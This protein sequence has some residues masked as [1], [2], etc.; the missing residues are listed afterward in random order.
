MNSNFLQKPIRCRKWQ[1]ISTNLRTTRFCSRYL[2]IAA[3]MSTISGLRD[4][5][6]T[7]KPSMSGQAESSGAFAAFADPPYWIR[8]PSAVC[9]STAV[10]IQSRMALCVSCACCG[11]A[12]TPVPMAQ[13]GSYAM[14]TRDLSWSDLR[15]GTMSCSWET[16]SA[17]TAPI[18]L[19]L[20]GRGSP[21][22]KMHCRPLSRMYCNFVANSPFDSAGVGSPNSPRR[23]EWP[24]RTVSIP[25]SFI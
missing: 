9:W 13:T 20:T 19:S 3:T 25:M 2:A 22:Q 18:P 6:P 7:K 16:H 24:M 1:L 4:A 10:A 8:I 17:R 11:V 5:P 23:S 12:V 14:T 21:M 15:I